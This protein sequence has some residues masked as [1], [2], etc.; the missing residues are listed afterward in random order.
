[1]V[2]V[3]VLGTLPH[4]DRV[5]E[6]AVPAECDSVMPGQRVRVKFSGKDHEGLVRARYSQPETDRPLAP[7]LKVVSSDVVISESMFRVCEHVA[8]RYAGS[9]TDVLR[10]AVPP[11]SASAEKQVRAAA[12][13][14]LNAD[15]H[16]PSDPLAA[17]SEHSGEAPTARAPGVYAQKFNGLHA[18]LQ[19]AGTRG[20]VVPRASIVL[21]PVDSWIDVV[22]ECI[23]TLPDGSGVLVLASDQKDVDRLS[24]ALASRKIEHGV[25]SSAAGPHKRYAA[26]LSVLSGRYSVVVGTRSA[27]FAPVAN[28]SLVVMY[29]PDD[30]LF[31]EPRAP[32]P[33]AREVVW[34]RSQVELCAALWVSQSPSSWA[35]V[36]E[37]EGRMASLSPVP[38]PHP[39][40]HPR[41]E[42]MDAYLREREGAS[43][44]SRLPQHAY[45]RIRDGLKAGPV[46]VSVPRAGYVPAL[47]CTFC[48]TRALCLTCHASLS[49][50]SS[51]RSLLQCSVCGRSHGAYRCPECDRTQLRPLVLGTGRTAE[52][53]ARAFPQVTMHVSGG[54]QGIVDDSSVSSGDLVVAT[55]GAEPLPQHGYAAA[56]IVD[57]ELALGRAVYDADT[58]SVRR[59]SHVIAATRAFRHGGEVLVLGR[60]P[61]RALRA[62]VLPRSH[63]FTD[64]VLA[65]RE[66]LHFP[67]L[68]RVVEVTGT[69]RAVAHFKDAAVVP[70]TTG[71]FGPVEVD[72]ASGGP[73]SRLVL[74]SSLSDSQ[75]LIDGVRAAFVS[76]SAAKAPGTLRVHVDPPHVF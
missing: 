52:D 76:H 54:A 32:Y 73:T 61:H 75:A 45:A 20:T 68:A 71:V 69:N 11:R 46:L 27:A 42:L 19:R 41:V 51:A 56:I 47:A 66:M 50:P 67:P 63:A 2:S 28:L 4:L 72:Q 7:L 8:R 26:F 33:H 18:L 12:K 57:P 35:R 17:S 16:S 13:R 23:D 21:D 37:R 39:D 58:E 70:A 5:F 38:A 30:D 15:K 64:A 74:R 14:P 40:T 53:L 1:M 65:E 29:D 60:S 9:T 25:L 3:H 24:R 43:G 22:I 10:L 31:E 36:H 59:F 6:Y 48:G 34:L 55:P 62:L 49:A 44:Y